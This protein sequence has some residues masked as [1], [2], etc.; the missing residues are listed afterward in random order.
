MNN[1]LFRLPVL[2]LAASVL[3]ASPTLA[4]PPNKKNVKA[5]IELIQKKIP[6]TKK[7]FKSAYAYAVFPEVGRGSFM[8]GG[9]Y[10]EGLVYK[11]GK[12]VG[13]ATLTQVTVGLGLGGEAY[14]EV[15]FFESKTA[16]DSFVAGKV[17]L[18]SQATAVAADVGVNGKVGF[19]NG[20]AIFTLTK[21]G[22][23]AD[24]SVGGQMLKFEKL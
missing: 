21:A 17:E 20:L 6:P 4:E 1:L 15:I 24:A 22:L 10:G 16:F 9:A 12:V 18:N 2:A 8:V 19:E 14:S 11:K 13:K 23:M 3:L 7:L 5:T